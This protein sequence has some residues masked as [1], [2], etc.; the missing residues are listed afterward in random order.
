M[1]TIFISVDTGESTTVKYDDVEEG[2]ETGDNTQIV[3]G[4]FISFAIIIIL[5]FALFYFLKR[6]KIC[7]STTPAERNFKLTVTN[8]KSL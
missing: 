4:I 1:I 7:F 3:V 8:F 2:N 6:R 5:T